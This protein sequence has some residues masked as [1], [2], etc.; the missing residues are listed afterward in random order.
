VIDGNDEIFVV[1]FD[2]GRIVNSKEQG[3][4]ADRYLCRWRRAVIKH[5]L[6][7]VLTE[8]L[9]SALRRRDLFVNRHH[10]R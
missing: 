5:G 1:D 10:I 8:V 7:D 4:L 6:S 2:K 9:C 3:R